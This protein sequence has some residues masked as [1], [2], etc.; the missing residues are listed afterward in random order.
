MSSTPPRA[1]LGAPDEA[2]EVARRA[3]AAL[4]SNTAVRPARA[5]SPPRRPRRARPGGRAA[6]RTTPPFPTR[7]RPSSNC[8][9]TSA[10]RSNRGAAQAT[11]AGS[12]LAQ[13]DERHV[14]GDQ[15]GRVRKLARLQ[16]ARVA[17][18]EHGDALVVANP[19]VELAVADV[20]GHDLGGTRLQQAVGEAPGRRADVEAAPAG[21]FD[22]VELA[23]RPL[24]LQPPARH[25]ARPLADADADVLG[26]QHAG[27]LCAR[28]G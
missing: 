28:A 25:V 8:G 7:S 3:R 10:S 11:T 19:P 2:L 21:D 22:L 16:V 17:A 13:S 15:V 18:L 27:L 26:H 1:G 14:D 23:Q 20:D 6:S 4:T 24:E 12:T 5:P 9:F